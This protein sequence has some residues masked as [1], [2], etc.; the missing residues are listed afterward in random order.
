MTFFGFFM[1]PSSGWNLKSVFS[2]TI[3]NVFKI[4][5]IKSE[6]QLQNNKLTERCRSGV[7]L[8][9]KYF[10]WAVFWKLC[11]MLFHSVSWKLLFRGAPFIWCM[12]NIIGLRQG[13]GQYEG[14]NI[15][16]A[17]TVRTRIRQ[18]V[19]PR[20]SGRRHVVSQTIRWLLL[21]SPT[22]LCGRLGHVFRTRHP[23]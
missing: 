15:W 18:T 2:C 5:D 14:P 21:P 1:K 6:I 8:W 3:E 4:W 10:C 22:R 9:S 19:P 7:P 16:N 13:C 12:W 17:P 11:V 23:T 20:G